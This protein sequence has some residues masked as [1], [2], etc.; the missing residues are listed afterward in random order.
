[1]RGDEGGL[2]K[3][4]EA[5]FEA[6]PLDNE[7]ETRCSVEGV[8]PILQS[9]EKCFDTS[10]LVDSEDRFGL[11]QEIDVPDSIAEGKDVR[12]FSVDEFD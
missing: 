11:A 9:S 12:I 6:T 2:E 10:S 8:K 3:S 1:L 7:P 5:R 4:S